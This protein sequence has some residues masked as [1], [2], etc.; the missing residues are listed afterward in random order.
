MVFD[1]QITPQSAPEACP[2]GVFLAPAFGA[3]SLTAS[4][5]VTGVLTTTR[6]NSALLIVNGVATT[7]TLTD[8]EFSTSAPLN[9]GENV[10]SIALPASVLEAARLRG[11]HVGRCGAGQHF[12]DAQGVSRCAGGRTR[13]LSQEGGLRP[14]GARHRARRRTADCRS[15]LPRAG[16]GLRSAHRWR[17]RLPGESAEGHARRRD[18]FGRRD[19]RAVVH[20][21]RIDRRAAAQRAASRRAGGAGV[22]A[23]A[24]GGDS[25]SAAARR[26]VGRRAAREDSRRRRHGAPP[27]ARARE[28]A[29]HSGSRRTST[30]SKRWARSWP[31]R[32][33]TARSS[34]R[35]ASI[36]SCRSR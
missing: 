27:G 13:A 19:R 11:P 18:R 24:G 36:R 8:R 21:H 7:V 17:R 6:F 16:H 34:S 15:W 5:T 3:G 29:G 33:A 26:G 23:A 30:R 2:R 35:A 32:R 9:V 25:G 20:A 1:L 22:A 10:L 14:V 4:T 31:R 12:D 28:R